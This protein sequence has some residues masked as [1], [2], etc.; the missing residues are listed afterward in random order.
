[1][2]SLGAVPGGQRRPAVKHTETRFAPDSEMTSNLSMSP[3]EHSKTLPDASAASARM[4]DLLEAF[5]TADAARRKQAFAD[6]LKLLKAAVKQGEFSQAAEGTR[7]AFTAGLDYT[8]AQSL[9]RIFKG[10]PEAYLPGTRLKLA[11]LG[12]FTTTQLITMLEL[13]LFAAGIVPEVYEADY[14][15]FS[16]EILDPTSQLY[17]FK[18]QVVFLATSWRDLKGAP[19][20]NTSREDVV[21]SVDAEVGRWQNLWNAAY[22]RLGCQIIQNNFDAPPWRQLGNFE[23]R[24]PAGLHRYVTTVNQALL[25]HAPPFV[26][27]H[28]LDHLAASIGRATWGDERFFHHAKIPCAPE[29]LVEYGHCIASLIATQQGLSKKCLVLDLDNTLWGGVIGDDG[30]GGIRLG[31]GDPE[32]EAFLAFQQ[33]LKSLKERGVIL[34]ICSKNEEGIAKEVFEKHREMALR[35][36]DISCFMANWEPKSDNLR[37]IAATLNIGSDALVFVDDNPAERALVR[38]FSP[39]ITVPELPEDPSG[40]IQAVERLRCFQVL[41]LSNEDLRRTELYRANSLRQ[42]QETSVT[43]IDEF[44]HSLAMRA[45]V[46]PIDNSTLERSAQLIN[47]SNQFNLTTRRRSA[48]EVLALVGDPAWVTRTVSLQDKFG[49][50]GLISVVLARGEQAALRVDT[51]LMSC[52]VLKRGVEHL[53]LNKLVELARQRGLKSIVGEYIPTPKNALVKDHYQN[54]GFTKFAEENGAASWR[55][56]IDDSWQPLPVHIEEETTS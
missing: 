48:A 13:S 27:I 26:T 1:M 40:Y 32:G 22:Q 21:Q 31:Q 55:L 20:L 15:I 44:L 6:L 25:D 33:Y 14:G 39:E 19:D 30:L 18:P 3:Q 49:D 41:S 8:S 54:L 34:A 46:A 24:H 51:W 42:L 11:V 9:H 12:G 5:T 35:L 10:I 50:N 43:N 16:Q 4:H 29:C 7:R 47:K 28:D 37:K 38:R 52:R 53:L 17:E 2:S 45:L 23:M 36:A 56:P